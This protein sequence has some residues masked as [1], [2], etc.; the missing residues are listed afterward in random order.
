MRSLVLRRLLMR[1]V[2]QEDEKHVGVLLPPSVG[3]VVTNAALTLAKRVAVNLNYTTSG[4]CP[5]PVHP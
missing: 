2:L 1:E 3:A 4:R 5:Q